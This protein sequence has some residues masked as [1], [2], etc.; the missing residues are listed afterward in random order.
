VERVAALAALV[1]ERPNSTAAACQL[2]LAQRQA[3]PSGEPPVPGSGSPIPH[4]FCQYWSDPEPPA[5]VAALLES[6]QR[7]HPEFDLER[8]HDRS[9]LAFLQAHCPPVIA[10]A[11]RSAAEPAMRADLFRLAWLYRRGGIYVDADDRCHGSL[12]PLLPAGRSLLLYV[13][14]WATLGNN[15]IGAAPGEPIIGA[16]LAQAVQAIARGDRDM[17][18]LSTGPAMLTRQVAMVAASPEGLPAS[19]AILD[20]EAVQRVV[21]MHCFLAYKSSER[22]WSNTTFARGARSG[23]LEALESGLDMAQV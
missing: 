17:V 23:R 12:L 10:H 4:R 3:A 13:E 9:A 19:V 11:F 1:R 7:H 20:K 16:A 18:W 22:H 21:S 14:D 15:L 6:W 2:L 5:D 8:F